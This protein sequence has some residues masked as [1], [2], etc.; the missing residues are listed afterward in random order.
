MSNDERRPRALFTK[1]SGWL[2]RAVQCCHA[3]LPLG[4]EAACLQ[5]R[6]QHAGERRRRA[7]ERRR[8]ACKHDTSSHFLLPKR[9]VLQ[10]P[11]AGLEPPPLAEEVSGGGFSPRSAASL[12]SAATCGFARPASSEAARPQIRTG[13]HLKWSRASGRPRGRRGWA[14][15]ARSQ[16]RAGSRPGTRRGPRRG[17]P[18]PRGTEGGKRRTHLNY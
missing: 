2:C 15:T 14:C 12:S 9:Y 1:D 7:G 5:E 8:R 10:P 13:D 17:L 3:A 18:S 16:R 11:P 6:R 4:E